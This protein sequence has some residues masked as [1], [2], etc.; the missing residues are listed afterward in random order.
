MEVAVSTGAIR[1]AK[2][3]SNYNYYRVLRVNVVS[4]STAASSASCKHS[5]LP[6]NLVNGQELTMCDTVRISPQSH[7]PLSVKPHFLWHALWQCVNGLLSSVSISACSCSTCIGV[8][9]ATRYHRLLLGP[10]TLH[11][12]SIAV[13]THFQCGWLMLQPVHKCCDF[14]GTRLVR[15]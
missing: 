3:Q 9:Y 7:S 10:E 8:Q 6:S 1:C 2:P 4:Q 11:L 13:E 5:R 15:D 14:S 12:F